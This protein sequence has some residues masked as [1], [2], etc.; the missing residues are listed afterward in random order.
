MKTRYKISTVIVVAF[1]LTL[2][3][4]PNVAAFSCNTM[5]VKDLHCHVVGM[6]FFGIPFKT[7]I[8]HWFEWNPPIGCG[9]VLA[10]PDKIYPC[11]G[12]EDYWGY[13]EKISP[14][15]EKE[16]FVQD[17]KNRFD[18]SLS[19]RFAPLYFDDREISLDWCTENNGF[20]SDD[21]S[22][23]YFENQ[24]N[25]DDGLNSIKQYEENNSNKQESEN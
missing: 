8:Y 21:D 11:I 12:I 24:K 17:T 18:E 10:H 2:F 19:I 15:S 3:I 14:F 16:P 4:P 13:P 20:W 23:C 7:N 1:L 22:T 5:N 6:T 9:G 25:L